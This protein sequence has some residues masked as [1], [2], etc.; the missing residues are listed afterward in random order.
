MVNDFFESNCNFY[1]RF[2][3]ILTF[4]ASLDRVKPE[5][6]ATTLQNSCTLIKDPAAISVVSLIRDSTQNKQNCNLINAKTRCYHGNQNNKSVDIEP[7][8]LMF[9][10]YKK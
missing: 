1:K 7:L 6:I 10:Q 8:V 4:L 3:L 9:I 5:V 2:Y